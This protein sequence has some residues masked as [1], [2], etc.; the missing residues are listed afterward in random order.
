MERA[1]PV[2]SPE[3]F[4]TAAAARKLRERESRRRQQRRELHRQAAGD[5]DAIIRFIRDKYNPR[6]I[7]QWGSV[8]HPERFDENSDIDIA[9]EGLRS[10]EEFFALYGDVMNMTEFSLDLVELEKVEPVHRD[11]IRKRGKIA[12]DRGH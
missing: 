3:T 7:Y 5:A 8:L 1:E 6:R 2:S 11:S 4:D 9:V 12:Y 10:A